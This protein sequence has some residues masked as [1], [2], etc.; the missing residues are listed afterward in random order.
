M[1]HILQES[2]WAFIKNLG[3][4]L[5]QKPCWDPS[6][7]CRDNDNIIL[8][9]FKAFIHFRCYVFPLILGFYLFIYWLVA[10]SLLLQSVV[11][12]T[13]CAKCKVREICLNINTYWFYWEYR[14]L[15]KGPMQDWQSFCPVKHNP[16][17]LYSSAY[18]SAYTSV[19]SVSS[20]L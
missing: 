1:Q 2:I 19:A 3:N 18:T 5:N 15:K 11:L 4:L 14:L 16:T 7:W 10:C 6:N 20:R 8:T 12:S 9:L 17:T 13:F